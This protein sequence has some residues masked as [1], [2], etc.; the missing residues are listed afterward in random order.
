M[1]SLI[2]Q[3]MICS[4]K[5]VSFKS[6]EFMRICLVLFLISTLSYA[7]ES[8]TYPEDKST[9]EEKPAKEGKPA[10]DEK[11]ANTTTYYIGEIR[12]MSYLDVGCTRVQDIYTIEYRDTKSRRFKKYRSFTFNKENKNLDSLY[13]MMRKGFDELPGEDVAVPIADEKV[14]LEYSKSAGTV[15]VRFKHNYGDNPKKNGLSVWMTKGRIN[16]LFGKD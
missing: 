6:F 15:S 3:K 14:W 5:L 11:T 12:S 9:K 7:Q 2:N 13:Q 10:K 8:E 1:I 4:F 16:K